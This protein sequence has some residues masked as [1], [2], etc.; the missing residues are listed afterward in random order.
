M[1]AEL[2]YSCRVTPQ[3]SASS[4]DVFQ[5]EDEG[6]IEPMIS[7][8]DYLKAVEEEELL[9]HGKGGS[10]D[11]IITAKDI[12]LATGF[13]LFVPKELK[14]MVPDYKIEPWELDFKN[15]AEI[16]KG[17]FRIASWRGTEVPVKTF[18]EGFADEDKLKDNTSILN[19]R[20]RYDLTILTYSTVFEARDLESGKIIALKKVRFDNFEPE[21][22]C[23]MAQEI[24]I[25]R[26][27]DHP[28]INKVGGINYFPII[29]QHISG[30][31]IL[32]IALMD[33]ACLLLSFWKDDGVEKEDKSHRTCYSNPL[34]MC[35][36]S[37]R[38]FS[39]D[40]AHMPVI[41]DPE[42][43][44]A[45]KDLMATNWDELPTA[46]VHDV[47]KALS[48]NTDDKAAQEALTNVLSSRG[49]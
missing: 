9:K 17:T 28:N 11:T 2:L 49:S 6:E 7:I 37:T 33:Y 12:I 39:E 27:L 5:A 46:V 35:I 10:G 31:G 38:S 47:K 15:N 14:L 30:G 45:F 4:A 21:S 32:R 1:K 23:F 41:E 18:W 48:K 43:E 36:G 24:M 25:L 19:R 26:R 22:V 20:R 16:T 44:R 13:V 34:A 3:I 8:G 42:I 29:M 40:V